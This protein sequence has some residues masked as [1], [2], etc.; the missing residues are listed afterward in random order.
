MSECINS[1]LH[2]I[3]A[4]NYLD[5]E[6]D[7]KRHVKIRGERRGNTSAIVI[8]ELSLLHL[9]CTKV[10]LAAPDSLTLSNSYLTHKNHIPKAHQY[11]N[12]GPR[13]PPFLEPYPI[14]PK[15]TTPRNH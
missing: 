12:H 9:I 13:K 1:L 14:P 4:Q 5:T 2:R 6:A 10:A 8:I 15:L 7:G 3:S 11:L